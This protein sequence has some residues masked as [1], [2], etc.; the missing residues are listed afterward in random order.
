M[1]NELA[2]PLLEALAPKSEEDFLNLYAIL[3]G[4]SLPANTGYSKGRWLIDIHIPPTYPITPPHIKFVTK[5]CHANVDWETGEICV[6]VL[7]ERWTPVLGIVGA[8]ECIGRLLVESGTDSP[9]G[10]EVAALERMG[11]H[12]GK[13]SLIGFWCEEERWRGGI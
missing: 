8:L 6:D 5:I 1:S 3:N 10:I 7:K 4:Q 13:R 9:L 2:S 11:D 12:V